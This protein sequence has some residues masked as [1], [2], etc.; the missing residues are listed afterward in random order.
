M[1]KAWIS[2]NDKLPHKL[3]MVLVWVQDD[4][5][6]GMMINDRFMAYID[7]EWRDR[8]DEVTHWQELPEPPRYE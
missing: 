6:F 8:H 7:S 1:M 4:Y 2:V 3:R 5:D